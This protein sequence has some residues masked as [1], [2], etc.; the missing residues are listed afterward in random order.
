M[1]GHTLGHIALVTEIDGVRVA[2]SEDLITQPGKVQTLD[3]LQYAYGVGNGCDYMVYSLTKLR[4]HHTGLLYPLHG[5]PFGD[6]ASALKS[7]EAKLRDYLSH[8]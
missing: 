2:F 6:T 1:P 3:D 5:E 4:E 8:R 7:L